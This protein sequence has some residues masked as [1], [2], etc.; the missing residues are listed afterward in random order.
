MDHEQF[1]EIT[2]ANRVVAAMIMQFPWHGSGV[3]AFTLEN[4]TA[5]SQGWRAP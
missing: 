5:M 1:L 2:A 4:N 3:Q